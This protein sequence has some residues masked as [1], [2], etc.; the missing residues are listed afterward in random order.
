MRATECRL[1]LLIGC[2]VVDAAGERVGRIEEVVADFRDG[3]Y[4]VRE[5]HLGAFAVLER[6]AGGRLGRGLLR[7][8]GGNRLYDGYI[9]PWQLMDLSDPEHPRATVAK[10]E[11]PRI[12][13]TV[14]PSASVRS[15]TPPKPQRTVGA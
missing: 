6:L 14:H 10:D 5:F 3:E 2:C 9:V 11:L 8:I 4:L 1:E 13:E 12:D 15:A 7:L